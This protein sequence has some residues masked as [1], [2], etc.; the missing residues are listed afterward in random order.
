MGEPT[1]KDPRPQQG[2]C[3][4]REQARPH[5]VGSLETRE[6]LRFDGEGRL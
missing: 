1:G 4:G 5:R 6:A 3:R 2:R